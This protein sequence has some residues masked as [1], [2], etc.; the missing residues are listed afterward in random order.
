MCLVAE[1]LQQM[2]RMQATANIT[3]QDIN[4]RLQKL[5]KVLITKCASNFVVNNDV[6]IAEFLP[7]STVERIKQFES[8]LKTTEEAVIQFVRILYIFIL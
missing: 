1:N 6:L 7:F 2:L 4:Q 5:E 8:L 3:L